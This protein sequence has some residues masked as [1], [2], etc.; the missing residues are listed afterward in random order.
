MDCQTDLTVQDEIHRISVAESERNG[1]S[2]LLAEVKKNCTKTR[3]TSKGSSVKYLE[4]KLVQLQL[5]AED[6]VKATVP[7]T[8]TVSWIAVPYFSLQTYAGLLSATTSSDFPTQTLLQAQ[9]SRITPER[10]KQ[11]VVC[12][13]DYSKEFECFHIA[14]VWCVVL[15]NLLITCGTMSQDKLGQDLISIVSEP[16]RDTTGNGGLEKIFVAYSEAVLWSLPL[17]ECQTWFVSAITGFNNGH[18]PPNTPD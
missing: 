4:P 9:Y 2:K 7:W 18:I 12:Q 17:S 3:Q 6:S 5:L 1:L 14:Q 15:D 16:F 13:G 10:D 8:R 11:Q